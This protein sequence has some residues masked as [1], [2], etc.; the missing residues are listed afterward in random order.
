MTE[1]VTP[2]QRRFQVTWLDT[3]DGKRHSRSYTRPASVEK[4][5]AKLAAWPAFFSEV[6]V[7]DQHGTR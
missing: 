1:L 6:K 3:R 4:R 5:L 7:E 2:K